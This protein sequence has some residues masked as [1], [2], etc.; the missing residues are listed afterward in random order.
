MSEEKLVKL[1]K[2]VETFAE[3]LWST[4]PNDVI[5]GKMDNICPMCDGCKEEMGH[6]YDCPFV[7]LEKLLEQM[8]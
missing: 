4:E 3:A 2:A 5:R 6:Y 8:N 7:P 1:K